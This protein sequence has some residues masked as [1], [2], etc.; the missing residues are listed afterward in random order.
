MKRLVLLF[1]AVAAVLIFAGA[2]SQTHAWAGNSDGVFI[3]YSAGQAE[4]EVV[5]STSVEKLIGDGEWEPFAVPGVVPG[6]TNVGTYHLSCR[7]LAGLAVP[8][9]HGYVGGGGTVLG[10]DLQVAYANIPGWYSIA[11]PQ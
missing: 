7:L 8:L 9:K 5:P 3:C 1:L 2:A 10:A 4:P 6:S 11:G